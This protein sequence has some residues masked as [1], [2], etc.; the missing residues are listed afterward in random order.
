MF[1]NVDPIIKII[2]QSQKRKDKA[3]ERIQFYFDQQI[4]SLL[5]EITR[6]WA[7]PDTFRLFSINVVRKIVNKRSMVYRN[8]PKRTFQNM[9]Q[10]TGE[11]LYESIGANTILKQANRYVT[12]LRTC[13]LQVGWNDDQPRIHILTPNILDVEFSDPENPDRVI[14][15]HQADRSQDVTYS[16]WTPTGFRRLDSKGGLVPVSGNRRSVNPYGRLP[17]VP[18]FATPPGDAFFLPGGSDLIDGQKAVNTALTNLWR[19][20]E[21]QSHG[22]SWAS[23]MDPEDYM[24]P[25]AHGPNSCIM[26]PAG[27]RF[28]FASPKTPIAEVLSAIEYLIK[29]LAISWDLGPAIFEID[30]RA[31]SGIAKVAESRDLLEARRDDIA[32]WRRYERELFQVIKTV[33]NTHIPWSIPEDAKVRVEFGE[34]QESLTEFE[35]LQAQQMRIEMGIESPVDAL[36]RENAAFQTRESAFAELQRRR[37][38]SAALGQTS[39]P[40]FRTDV[41]PLQGVTMQNTPQDIGEPENV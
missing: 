19:A 14:V 4:D 34:I 41:P 26:L 33:V 20:I 37:E 38:E 7:D 22:Q 15:T 40:S 18:I 29:N 36:M 21:L 17:F 6:K 12:L 9:D 1:G 10:E 16:D 13:M 39:T 5:A 3:A 23:G 2:N 8:P 11:A 32:L 28:D 31:E 30:Q 24:M 27:G 25:L 35:R